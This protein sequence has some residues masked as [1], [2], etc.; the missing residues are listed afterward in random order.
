MW[1]R[2]RLTER[3]N[4]DW[5]IFSAPM[6]PFATPSLAAGVSNAGGIGGLGMTSFTPEECERRIAGF[7]Q[8]SGRSL[9]AN[10]LLWGPT[11]NLDGQYPEMRAK[12]GQYY[13]EEGLGKALDP[14]MNA[15]SV[16]PELL[17]VLMATKPE[18]VSFHWGLPGQEIVQ[19]LKSNGSM[20]VACATTVAEARQLEALGADAI[21][22]QGLEAGGHRG[23][24]TDVDATM[25][26]GLFALLPQIV[27][28]CS[29][30][31]IAAGGVSNGRSIAAAMVLG[32][33]AVWMGTA[34][35]RSPEALVPDAHRAALRTAG[36]ASTIVSR[37]VSG[38]PARVLPNKLTR[39]LADVEG[40]PMP[41]PAQLSVVKPLEASEHG[42]LG[43]F[44][45]GQGVALTSELPAE[46]LMA[47]LTEEAD[48]H[49]RAMMA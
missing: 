14:A 30:P 23:T 32:A 15:S 49:L 29:V 31:I 13:Q 9:N 34:F 40:G 25:Q 3:L 10:L 26:A 48:A 7:R 47:Q 12:L 24:F 38:K 28:A 46:D 36:D 43:Q 39:E 18:V 8:L 21:I 33:E 11:G 17:D 16:S 42:D 22:A 45:S 6:T 44:Y 1:H 2:T 5:P 27:N 41:F 4:L 20:I 19:A 35:L 37:L